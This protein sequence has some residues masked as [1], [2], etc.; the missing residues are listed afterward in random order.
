[1]NDYKELTVQDIINAINNNPKLFPEG[2]NTPII[3]GD[4]EVKYTHFLHAISAQYTIHGNPAI[5]LEYEIDEN[6][7][8]VPK[9]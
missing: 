5:C 2:M 3:S 7:G 6:C 4:F 8:H 1:M 9:I